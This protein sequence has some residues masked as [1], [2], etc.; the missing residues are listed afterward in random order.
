MSLLNA[1]G[2]WIAAHHPHS[3]R[4]LALFPERNPMPV[5]SLSL[6]GQVL[7]ANPAAHALATRLLGNV[8]Q[9]VGL[10]PPQLGKALDSLNKRGTH[11]AEWEYAV[12]DTVLDTVL[13]CMADIGVCHAYLRDITQQHRAEARLQRQAMHDAIT[14]LPNQRAFLAH[15]ER[16]LQQA[17][18]GGVLLLHVN[19]FHG[20]IKSLGHAAGESV[21]R[22]L[23]E[24]LQ[25]LTDGQICC[26]HRFEG[27]LFAVLLIT[28]TAAESAAMLHTQMAEAMHTPVVVDGHTLYFSLSAGLALFPQDGTDAVT[29]L[30]HA[31]TALQTSLQT[32]R[33][34]VQHYH[35]RMDAS[36]LARLDMEHAL[37]D[38]EVRGELVL[39]YQ[40]QVDIHNGRIIGAEALVRWQHPIKGFIS[41]AEFIPLAEETGA[42]LPMGTWILRMACA[43]NKAWQDQGLEP[44]VVAVNLSPMQFQHP[45]LPEQVRQVLEE[46]G[47]SPQ[48]LELEITEGAAMHDLDRAVD[49]LQAFRT[50]GV[51]LSIDDFG[52]G[53][54]SLA[55][56]SRFP[57][58]KLK[59]DQSFVRNMEREPADAA[60]ARSVVALGRGLGLAVIAEGV[61]TAAQLDHLRTFGCDEIQGYLFSRPLPAAEISTLLAAP[62]WLAGH[63]T[64]HTESA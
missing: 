51:R 10:L 1:L 58:D 44:I 46:I 37:R 57:I 18:S 40:P 60:I 14:G 41:P 62:P 45:D 42:I 16:L 64:I 2:T 63:D 4:R 9:P 34:E 13:Y 52:T 27:E 3:R 25:G 28:E 38:V 5:F 21:L 59:V 56:L 48:W 26:V 50:L 36:A 53:H 30:R 20:V 31:D 12:A 24:R 23:G 17:V 19:R 49:T 7:Y 43:Q 35:A 8:G 29:L 61:E 15:L 22:A 54:S 6:T 33:P 39:H 55:Y 11:T 32:A 47:L